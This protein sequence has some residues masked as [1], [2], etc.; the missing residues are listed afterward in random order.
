M[1]SAALQ[2]VKSRQVFEPDHCDELMKKERLAAH[3]LLM[4]LKEKHTCHIKGRE[5]A[6]G[7]K[8]RLF[9]QEEDT[10]LPTVALESLFISATCA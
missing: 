7:H 4:F 5:C 9:V 2:Q 1:V 8:Q 3:K 10:S 6:D